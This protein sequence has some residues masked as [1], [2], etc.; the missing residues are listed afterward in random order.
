VSSAPPPQAAPKKKTST[1]TIVLAVIGGGFVLVLLGLAVAAYAVWSNPEGRKFVGMLGESMKVMQKAQK[2][3]GTKELRAIGCG[4]AM[5]LDME[6]LER[7]TKYIDSGGV[8]M[9]SVIGRMVVCAAQPWD[10]P[11]TC[12]A[13]VSKYL[14]VVGKVDRSVLVSVTQSGK[15]KPVCQAIYDG[16]GTKL[17][18]SD[19]DLG[20]PPVE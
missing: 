6:D 12:D 20:L 16:T 18:D 19:S 9:P 7:I 10:T 11:P 1:L 14:S 4:Q 5:A 15:S 17:Q 13:V 3:P 2:A 8:S